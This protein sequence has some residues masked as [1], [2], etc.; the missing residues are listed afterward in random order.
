M[1]IWLQVRPIISCDK[2][3]WLE[4][5]VTR[6]VAN[7]SVKYDDAV[8]SGLTSASR[9]DYKSLKITLHHSNM[10]KMWNAEHLSILESANYF[11]LGLS[12][13]PGLQQSKVDTQP[14]YLKS[15]SLGEHHEHVYMATPFSVLYIYIYIYI[16]IYMAILPEKII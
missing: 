15:M 11:S 4:S 7:I 3:N 16:Y 10:V 13:C 5:I 14:I 12:V 9:I 6:V 8:N 2:P 1:F